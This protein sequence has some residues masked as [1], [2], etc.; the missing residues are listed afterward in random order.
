MQKSFWVVKNDKNMIPI[1]TVT[2]FQ[3]MLRKT[4]ILS[5]MSSQFTILTIQVA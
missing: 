2:Q 1:L 5:R 4:T 3:K